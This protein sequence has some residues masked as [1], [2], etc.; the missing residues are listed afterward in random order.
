[1]STAGGLA[2][3]KAGRSEMATVGLWGAGSGSRLGAP[4]ELE[5]VEGLEAQSEEAMAAPW[6]L[7]LVERMKRLRNTSNN[8]RGR[9]HN[10][11]YRHC[12]RDPI[13]W[14][15]RLSTS[16]SPAPMARRWQCPSRPCCHAKGRCPLGHSSDCSTRWH[17]CHRAATILRL[18][19]QDPS[20]E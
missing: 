13:R 16:K 9:S 12:T 3:G 4:S 10:P 6:E 5:M 2:T 20:L 15:Q 7:V 8:L 17:G 14:R 1:M 11:R 19:W 18:R